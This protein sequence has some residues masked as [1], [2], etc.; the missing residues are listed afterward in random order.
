MEEGSE[1]ATTN[2]SAPVGRRTDAP[3]FWRYK[4]VGTGKGTWELL[5][6]NTEADGGPKL[7]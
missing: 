7:M 1:S 2:G 4:A 6:E 5:S 3:D